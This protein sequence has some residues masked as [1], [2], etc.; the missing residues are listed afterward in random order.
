VSTDSR[1]YEAV[2]LERGKN[3]ARLEYD[4]CGDGAVENWILAARNR[5]D[6]EQF[7]RKVSLEE[8]TLGEGGDK[9]WKSE[10]QKREKK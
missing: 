9:L 3:L 5:A 2:V 7:A 1:E 8:I 10:I 4:E 6:G